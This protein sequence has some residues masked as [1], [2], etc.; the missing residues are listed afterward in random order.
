M[1]E[2]KIKRDIQKQLNADPHVRVFNCP[3]GVFYQGEIVERTTTTITLKNPRRVDVGLVK[4]GSDLIGWRSLLITADM[5]GSR[6]AQFLGIETKD[7]YK[8]PTAE[9]IQFITVVNN[10]GGAAGVAR[11]TEDAQQILMAGEP[12]NWGG[13]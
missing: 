13:A 3:T 9:Q 6:I 12:R 7:K 10:A 11:S 2:A 4:G 8:K 1:S 5:V